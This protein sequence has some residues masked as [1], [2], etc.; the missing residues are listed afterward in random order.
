MSPNAY[1]YIAQAR[2]KDLPARLSFTAFIATAAWFFDHGAVAAGWLLAVCAGLGRG[3]LLHAAYNFPAV[4]GMIALM[5]LHR[6]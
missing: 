3:V 4:I 2:S 5:T 1:G 6:G